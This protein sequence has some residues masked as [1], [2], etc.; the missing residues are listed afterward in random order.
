MEE[1]MV[2]S[3]GAPHP[4]CEVS[5]MFF[6]FADAEKTGVDEFGLLWSLVLP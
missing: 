3:W 1:Q 4:M 5:T 2:A 6:Y